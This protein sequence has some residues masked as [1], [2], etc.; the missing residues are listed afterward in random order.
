MRRLGI[1]VPVGRW[2]SRSLDT[3]FF[4]IA[5]AQGRSSR[6]LVF[7]NESRCPINV[8]C[9]MNQTLDKFL[10]VL[11]SSQIACTVCPDG[12][13]GKAQQVAGDRSPEARGR[14]TLAGNAVS[15]IG[16]SGALLLFARTASTSILV[17]DL[18]A[19]TPTSHCQVTGE[20]LTT[21]FSPS[22]CEELFD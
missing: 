8:W 6:I 18:T 22:H 4:T 3:G 5:T 17:K 12:T 16:G 11:P 20:T 15:I 7:A 2:D 19:S 1:F 9:V 21:S 10:N 14:M 13:L